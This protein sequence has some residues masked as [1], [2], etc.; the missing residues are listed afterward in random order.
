MTQTSLSAATWTTPE[1]QRAYSAQKRWPRGD[2]ILQWHRH[3]CLCAVAKQFLIANLELEFTLSPI[4]I[5]ELKISNRK[6][7]TIFHGAQP[8][9]HLISQATRHSSPATPSLI[10]TP[11]LEITI[12]PILSASSN[13]LI[14]TKCG[15]RIPD[16]LAGVAFSLNPTTKTRIQC[17]REGES[18]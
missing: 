13:F 2:S 12:S 8:A 11:R 4:K 1:A 5:S 10:E 3:S 9:S 18:A 7:S 6:F 14:G 15:V 17:G 16:T